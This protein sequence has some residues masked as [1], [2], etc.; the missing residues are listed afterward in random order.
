MEEGSPIDSLKQRGKI[1]CVGA[2]RAANR[3]GVVR[4]AGSSVLDHASPV[5]LAAYHA[6]PLIWLADEVKLGYVCNAFA[7][8]STCYGKISL[9]DG[10]AQWQPTPYGTVW[11]SIQ[12][13]LNRDAS[14]VFGA[15]ERD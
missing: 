14:Y 11:P 10:P 9:A 4:R 3:S 1:L 15:T 12:P 7:Y 13:G 2:E 8:K 5:D 6:A